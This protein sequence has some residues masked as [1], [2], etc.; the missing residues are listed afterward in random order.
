MLYFSSLYN[1]QNPK[2]YTRINAPHLME[3]V[4][5]FL[6]EAKAKTGISFGS[7]KRKE[8]RG[9]EHLRTKQKEWYQSKMLK[10]QLWTNDKKLDT[11]A[12]IENDIMLDVEDTKRKNDNDIIKDIMWKIDIK[13]TTKPD[14]RP[15]KLNDI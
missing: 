11:T 2:A 7:E 5:K 9:E 4:S 1:V 14:E 6:N 3:T 15:R 13:E 12:T 10:R 8:A